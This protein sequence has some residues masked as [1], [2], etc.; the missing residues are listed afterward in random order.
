MPHTAN[1]DSQTYKTRQLANI[2]ILRGTV[3]VCSTCYEHWKL[4]WLSMATDGQEQM[5]CNL[6]KL[7]LLFQVLLLFR[8]KIALNC[9][10]LFLPRKTTSTHNFNKVI[11]ECRDSTPLRY[12]LRESNK[13]FPLTNWFSGTKSADIFHQSGS[14]CCHKMLTCEYWV[15]SVR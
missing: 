7:G 10:F 5:D 3:V 9:Y 15:L 14:W 6:K 4:F 2:L 12:L 1:E 8:E 13:L 11:T